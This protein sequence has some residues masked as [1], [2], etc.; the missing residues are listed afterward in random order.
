MVNNKPVNIQKSANW[1]L[2]ALDQCWKTKQNS[3]RAEER[4]AAEAMYKN[5]RKIY[6]GISTG[7]TP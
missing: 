3:I 1:C 7:S 2:Q 4:A 5:A 6:E